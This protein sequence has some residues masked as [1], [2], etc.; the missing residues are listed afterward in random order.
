MTTKNLFK[1]VFQFKETNC[2]IISDRKSAIDKAIS[3]IKYHRDELDRYV[4]THP[5]FLYSLEPVSAK[6]GPL[7]AR[8]MVEASEKVNVGPM[9]AVAGALADRA[10]R[11][12]IDTGCRIAIVENG[13]E[14][15]AV[16]N[17]PIDIAL[18][19]GDSLLSKQIGFRLEEF[20]TGVATSSGLFSHA[21]SFGEAEAVTVFA[22]NAGLADAV[23][24]AVGNLVKGDDCRGAIERGINEALSVEGVK[25]VFISYRGFVGKA[26]QI[27]KM[28]KVREE[29]SSR[30]FS[31]VQQVS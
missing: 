2:F 10:V 16:S 8:L 21:L 26:G 9:A 15:S 27:P 4:K 7:I 29:D 18:L 28:I 6:D 20:P 24:T 1:Q 11:D 25:G 13:G 5:K 12:M 23:S 22:V 3:S 17:R 30:I 14:V 31:A 19:A